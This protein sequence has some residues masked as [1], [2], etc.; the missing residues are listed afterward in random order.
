MLAGLL[1]LIEKDVTSTSHTPMDSFP[2]AGNVGLSPFAFSLNSHH[3]L[4]S[5][6]IINNACC[7]ELT[8]HLR[9]SSERTVMSSMCLLGAH[10][11]HRVQLLAEASD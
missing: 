1:F 9:V 5:V 2:L 7:E 4:S 6:A 3:C 8:L 11:K 10:P